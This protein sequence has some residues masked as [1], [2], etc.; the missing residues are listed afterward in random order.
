M[1]SAQLLDV[2]VLQLED[3]KMLGMVLSRLDANSLEAVKAPRSQ[4]QRP[5]DRV[6][7][8]RRRLRDLWTL[9]STALPR[10]VYRESFVVLNLAPPLHLE[11]KCDLPA[12]GSLG[13]RD[14][15]RPE[16]SMQ[17]R[18]PIVNNNS[19]SRRRCQRS[20]AMMLAPAGNYR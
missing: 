19:S 5:R 3:L 11:C 20:S 6:R 4:W 7:R 16:L 17:P 14:R 8:V 10:V 1:P 15:K 2:H 9:A 18:T 12:H 13:R